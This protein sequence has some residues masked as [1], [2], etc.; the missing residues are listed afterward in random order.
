MATQVATLATKAGL[1]MQSKK[2]RNG[3][4]I[5]QHLHL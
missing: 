5:E 2:A 4:N 1:T 3:V